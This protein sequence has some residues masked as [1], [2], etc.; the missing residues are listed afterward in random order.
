MSRLYC[1]QSSPLWV[2]PKFPF[3]VLTASNGYK[4]SRYISVFNSPGTIIY[5][6]TMAQ[7]ALS[8]NA[9]GA[10]CILQLRHALLYLSLTMNFIQHL[11]G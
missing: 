10:L 1:N 8:L 11:S 2:Q 3:V 9:I 4:I 7:N 5:T 6:K